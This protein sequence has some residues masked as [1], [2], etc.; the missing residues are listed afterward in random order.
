MLLSGWSTLIL[1]H[2][3]PPVP[4]PILWWLYQE[5]QL[6]LISLSLLCSIVF[7]SSQARSG[8]FIIMT[9]FLH[10]TFCHYH[11]IIS[12]SSFTQ[13]C[14][15]FYLILIFP[16]FCKVVLFVVNWITLTRKSDEHLRTTYRNTEQ[17][18]R[19]Y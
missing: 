8:Y 3:N 18:F 2:P 6:L 15:S 7:F 4:V 11:F 10:S 9:I 14:V 1:L 5:V 16:F 19:P 13:V 17:L 12:F